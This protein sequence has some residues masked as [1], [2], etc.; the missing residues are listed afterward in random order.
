MDIQSLMD[1]YITQLKQDDLSE[2]LRTKYLEFIH[3]AT[4]SILIKIEDQ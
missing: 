2:E 1:F 3:R 4:E